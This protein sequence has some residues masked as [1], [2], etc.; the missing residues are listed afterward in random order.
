MLRTSRDV[1]SDLGAWAVPATAMRQIWPA[2]VGLGNDRYHANDPRW[3]LAS[4]EARRQ[5][6]ASSS[7]GAPAS[8]QRTVIRQIEAETVTVI[9]GGH[10]AGPVNIGMPVSERRDGSGDGGRQ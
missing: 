2:E 8:A 6:S 9:T 7:G 4:L 3:H 10:F 1:D 5:S